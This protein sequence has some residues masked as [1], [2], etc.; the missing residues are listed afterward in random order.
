MIVSSRPNTHNDLKI[1]EMFFSLKIN[2]VGQAGLLHAV[3]LMSM[4]TKMAFSFMDA[5]QS[6]L[7]KSPFQLH[8]RRNE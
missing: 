6:C 5:F 8:G 7:G 4:I 3:I 2:S 1:K